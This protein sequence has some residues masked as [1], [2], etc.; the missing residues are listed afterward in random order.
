MRNAYL[1]VDIGTGNARVG[2]IAESGEVLC[3]RTKNTCFKRDSAYFD[4]VYF[5]PNKL[6]Q[7]VCR[8]IREA[9]SALP[10]DVNILALSA[11]SRAF[12]PAVTAKSLALSPNSSKK[13]MKSLLSQLALS[14]SV[15]NYSIVI[16][17]P[18]GKRFP[19]NFPK[20]GPF[21]S[22]KRKKAQFPLPISSP[23][24]VYL[25]GKNAN[26]ERKVPLCPSPQSSTSPP[27]T[28]RR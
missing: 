25:V 15:L 18:S 16:F 11:T 17:P 28:G 7:G 5:D 22:G 26:R 4:S 19:L 23:S 10:S 12:S 21:L 1:I 20:A 8:S 3:V 14:A 24:V 27:A 13:A 9:L 2:I 6:F